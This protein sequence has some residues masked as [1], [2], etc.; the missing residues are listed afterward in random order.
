MRTARLKQEEQTGNIAI[1]KQIIDILEEVKP[2]QN[3]E[4]HIDPLF[5]SDP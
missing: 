4:A 5:P 3:K 1:E 2:A